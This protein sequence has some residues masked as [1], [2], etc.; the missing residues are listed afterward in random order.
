[1]GELE[2]MKYLNGCKEENAKPGVGMI[3]LQGQSRRIRG[4]NAESSDSITS[5]EKLETNHRAS[6]RTNGIFCCSPCLYILPG[7]PS[8][9]GVLAKQSLLCSTSSHTEP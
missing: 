4:R 1:M 7:C 6:Y 2:H 8:A 9:G 3:F 5:K